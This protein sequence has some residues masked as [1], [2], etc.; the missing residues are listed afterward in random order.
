M[1]GIISG[2][3]QETITEKIAFSFV[4]LYVLLRSYLLV[5]DTVLCY[6]IFL[7]N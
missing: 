5:T 3:A 7:A 4:Y 1:I 2:V 6:L